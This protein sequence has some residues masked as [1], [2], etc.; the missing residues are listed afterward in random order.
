MLRKSEYGEAIPVMENAVKLLPGSSTAWALLGQ[1][2]QFNRRWE[3][4]AK[5]FRK[6]VEL[7][8][9]NTTYRTALGLLLGIVGQFE[10]GA[11]ELKKVVATPGY[12]EAAG[13][14]NLGWIY[15]N[16]KPPKTE[17]SIAAY[18]KALELDP[19]EEQAAL[20]LGWAYS[21]T[22]SWDNAIAAFNKAVEI[23]PKT[24]GEAYNGIAWCYFFK[25][26]FANAKV[27]ME[28]A[29]AGGRNDARLKENIERVEKAI[30]AGQAVSD[31]EIKRAEAEQAK[32]REKYEKFERANAAVRSKN[33]LQRIGGC[34]D[35]A[36]MAGG[37]AVSTLVFMMQ[38]D[39][40]YAVREACTAALGSLG[41][42]A[43]S[44]LPNLKAMLNHACD[45]SLTQTTEQ[46]A[47]AMKCADFKR[48][49][50]DALQKVQ[51]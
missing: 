50:R 37:D 46:M 20:G 17:D 26:D 16:M 8:P 10:E 6:A 24:A 43:K 9:A 47:V 15:R 40:D 44:G 48:A 21:Y 22:K 32:E 27:F 28:K 19:K 36:A 34:R 35:L 2:Y 13:W 38:N 7:A 18:K 14:A 1:T 42:A 30:A 3:D 12:K 29:Q 5:A 23:E 49:V 41:A 11:A 33:A 25:K 4:A 39:N 31:D 45:D 51:K